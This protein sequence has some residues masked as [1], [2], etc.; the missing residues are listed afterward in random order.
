MAAGN[1]LIDFTDGFENSSAP[2]NLTQTTN[3]FEVHANDAAFEAANGAGQEGDVYENSTDNTIHM[4]NGTAWISVPDA[5]STTTFTNKTLDA[6]NN[7]ITNI[8]ET[9]M[10]SA[11]QAF[12]TL[13]RAD[14]SGAVTW[15]P[16][17]ERMG[18]LENL[19][20]TGA[21][22]SSALTIALKGANG[23]DASATNPVRFAFRNVTA[24]TGTPVE[25]AV[26]GALS[27]VIS[28]GSTL[29]HISAIDHYIY[30]YAINNAGT[31]VLGAS[32]VLFDEGTVQSATAEGGAG[33]ADTASV[34]YATATQTS[35]A[36]RLIGRFKSNQAAA[37]TWDT[38]I[39]EISL[40]P[41]EIQVV[42]ASYTTNAG[43]AVSNA[44][45]TQLDFEDKVTDTHGSV[46]IGASWVYTAKIKTIH[47]VKTHLEYNETTAWG[48]GE[49]AQ[50][51]V[52]KNGSFFRTIGSY[53]VNGT[54]GQTWLMNVQGAIDILLDV[55]DTISIRT[56]QTSG[57]V[58]SIYAVADRD[59]HVTI[60]A[61]RGIV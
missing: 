1:R 31:V 41:F 6:D 37:G 30:I 5:A 52:Y 9:E 25:V 42:H 27:L 51:A 32:S 8:D 61:V 20:L 55:G 2:S 34:M 57:G 3:A 12:G 47:Q 21:V 10:S 40:G 49:R 36:I 33:A 45:W 11:T 50:L 14:G 58:R 18:K 16:V 17:P 26:T 7:T 29:G 54:V 38:A 4:Y 53:E 15:E 13:P 43:Q 44:T 39:S 56:Y 23:S 35:K 24:A 28:S 59:S 46:T 19:A 22:A 60:T 48:D